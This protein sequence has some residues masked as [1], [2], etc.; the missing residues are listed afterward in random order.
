MCGIQA[1]IFFYKHND[2]TT[3]C[4][5]REAPAFTHFSFSAVSYNSVRRKAFGV[6]YI[7]LLHH[8]ISF[9]FLCRNFFFVNL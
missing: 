7:E 3:H 4:I 8:K 9:P 1:T 6:I 5:Y 2:F